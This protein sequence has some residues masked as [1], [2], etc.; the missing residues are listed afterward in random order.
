[1]KMFALAR[2]EATLQSGNFTRQTVEQ[3]VITYSTI[4]VKCASSSE[5]LGRQHR[6]SVQVWETCAG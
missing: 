5:G 1:M 2:G 6:E 4:I 3:E